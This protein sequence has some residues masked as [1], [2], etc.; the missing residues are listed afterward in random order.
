[1]SIRRFV[2]KMMY[3]KNLVKLDILGTAYDM[4][5]LSDEKAEDKMKDTTMAIMDN[6][7]KISDIP[8]D[9]ILDMA[10]K[11]VQGA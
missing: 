11:K 3:H 6:L 8:L 4:G 9:E 2:N 5:L 1:M 10:D 7:S